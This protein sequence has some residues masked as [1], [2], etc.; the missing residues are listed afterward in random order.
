M[1]IR[2]LACEYARPL[3]RGE[4]TLEQFDE[5]LNRG[6]R[7]FIEGTAK[8]RGAADLRAAAKKARS[9]VK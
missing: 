1:L 6:V 8:V 9:R 2:D 3:V 7:R 4:I 5:T